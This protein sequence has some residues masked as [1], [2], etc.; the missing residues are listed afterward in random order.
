M[1]DPILFWNEVALEA[2]RLDHTGAME[3]EH[4]KGP[5]RSARAL[6]I[7]HLAMHDAFFGIA[8]VAAIPNLPP[9][10]KNLYLLAPI[11]P[12]PPPLP[13]TPLITRSAAVSGAA[14]TTLCTLYS[15]MRI[16]IEEKLAGI[17]GKNGTED[18]AFCFGRRVALAVLATR[19]N[20]A[21]VVPKDDDYISS[22]GRLRHRVDPCN[23]T[24][25]YLGVGDGKAP[26]F[27]T[28]AWLM[29]SP[30]PPEADPRYTDDYSEVYK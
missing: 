18:A 10:P 6:A 21:N 27:A 14:A 11:A 8:G 25:G 3:A 24:Q 28:T 2:N 23:R 1:E 22:P 9:G 20:D 5:T 15:G 16:R 7:V 29:L 12:P 26:S 4:Q 17:S 13:P 30:P 19:A